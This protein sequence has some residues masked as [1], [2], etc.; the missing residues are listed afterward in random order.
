[1]LWVID[2][3]NRDDLGEL[4]RGRSGHLFPEEA[5]AWGVGAIRAIRFDAQRPGESVRLGKS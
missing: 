5:F 4:H 1:M 2:Y 3:E